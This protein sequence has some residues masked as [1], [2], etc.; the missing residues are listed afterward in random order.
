MAQTYQDRPRANG[1]LTDRLEAAR[2]AAGGPSKS[3]G[4][5]IHESQ[6]A[7]HQ[8]ATAA[9]RIADLARGFTTELIRW[10]GNYAPEMIVNEAFALARAFVAEAE[11][12]PATAPA[13]T[14]SEKIP[15]EKTGE[16]QER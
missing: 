10:R 3:A 16:S 11:K 6:P 5:V 8:Y 13:S 12:T 4:E 7:Q 15:Q 14:M 1:R 2:S 9:D